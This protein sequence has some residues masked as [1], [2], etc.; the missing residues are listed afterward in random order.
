MPSSKKK[1]LF[2][3]PFFQFTISEIFL[4]TRNQQKILDFSIPLFQEKKTHLLEGTF[5][6]V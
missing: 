1:Y 5:C 2:G 3:L 4:P 6:T